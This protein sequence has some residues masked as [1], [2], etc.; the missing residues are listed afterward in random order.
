MNCNGNSEH[1]EAQRRFNA[2][3][4]C[5]SA[6]WIS[7]IVAQGEGC[8][9]TFAVHLNKDDGS[10]EI[11]GC[12]AEHLV[13]YRAFQIQVLRRSGVIFGDYRFEQC[14]GMTAFREEVGKA[15]SNGVAF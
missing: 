3:S 1:V 10:T 7:A 5:R 4:T 2:Q 11:V 13:S 9:L 12:G 15:L 14:D 6:S 8:E